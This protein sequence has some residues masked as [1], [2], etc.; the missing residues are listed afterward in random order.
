V[1]VFPLIVPVGVL[2]TPAGEVFVTVTEDIARDED[3]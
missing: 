2:V 3:I 1:T